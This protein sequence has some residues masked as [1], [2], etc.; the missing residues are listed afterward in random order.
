MLAFAAMGLFMPG[1]A[2][3]E[4]RTLKIYHVHLNEH[5]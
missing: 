4:T 1:N 3:A 2:E 5:S